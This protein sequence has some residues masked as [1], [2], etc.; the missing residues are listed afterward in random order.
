MFLSFIIPVYN[1]QRYLPECLDSLLAQDIAPEDY[2]VLCINDGSKDDSLTILRQ[3]A[4]KHPNV[5]VIDKENG[6][7]TTARNAG[8]AAAKGDYIWFIDADDFI[9]ENILGQLRETIAQTDCDRLTFGAYQ[10][11]DA[12]TETE[13]EQSRQGT[14]P[15][16][17]PWYDSVV[18]RCLLRRSFLEANNLT[19]RYPELTHGEDGLFMHEVTLCSPAT[20]NLED[21]LY[22]YRIHS[23]SAETNISI[24][25][26]LKKLRSFIR[27]TEILRDY[28][29]SLE[30]PAD[31]SANKF[32]SFLWMTL[33]EIT[34][35]PAKEAKAAIREL[36]QKGL[37]PYPRPA[38]CTMDRSYMT[39]RTDIIGKVFDKVYLNLH[40]P[41]GYHTMRLLQALMGLLK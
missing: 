8:L 27:I 29:A 13:L 26:R 19:F 18:W 41:W 4:E 10:F 25:N 17:T 1:A 7:V 21:V 23:G 3:Y 38:Q 31:G 2:E 37:F 36:K 12:L 32:F 35:L 20:V 33:Y 5:T 14:L 16:N 28:F 6:G 9:K 22:F 24:E 11:T 34:R 40:T 39:D 15:I 30:A